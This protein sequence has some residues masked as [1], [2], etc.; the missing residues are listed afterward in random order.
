MIPSLIIHIALKTTVYTHGNLHPIALAYWLFT[1][2]DE[3]STIVVTFDGTIL[4]GGAEA[5]EQMA[6]GSDAVLVEVTNW[7][8]R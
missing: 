2:D 5:T 4:M 1:R 8:S 6:N 3:V 7:F